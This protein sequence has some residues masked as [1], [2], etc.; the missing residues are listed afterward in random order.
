MEEEEERKAQTNLRSA[1]CICGV[2]VCTASAP[3]LYRRC[4]AGLYVIGIQRRSYFL[5]VK[6]KKEREKVISFGSPAPVQFPD[7]TPSREGRASILEL[8]TRICPVSV[9]YFVN[10]FTTT[11]IIIIIVINCSAVVA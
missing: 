7:D 11:L 6:K 1:A 5:R 2:G 9:V 8:Q 4:V 3:G 10:T